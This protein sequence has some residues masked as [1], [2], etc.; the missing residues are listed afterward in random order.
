M[1]GTQ[2]D[3]NAE[4]CKYCG[5][6]FENFSSPGVSA[7]GWSRPKQEQAPSANLDLAQPSDAASTFPSTP[8]M[9]PTG[10]ALFVVSRSL[11]TSLLPAIFYLAF[12]IFT[13]AISS[14]DILSIALIAVFFLIAAVPVLFTPRKYEF[15]EGSLRIH[16]TVGR[17]SEIPYSNLMLYDVTMGRRQQIVL[18]VEGQRRQIL[19][20]GNPKNQELGQDLKQF[21]EQRVKKYN[22]QAGN[23][24]APQE[25]S[26]TSNE[27]DTMNPDSGI[28][29]TEHKA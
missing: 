9:I 1:C 24:Q 6:I 22:P 7:P 19:I 20:P 14:L 16:K 27:E 4:S 23:E 29:A 17:D 18:S 2:N 26:L 25:E 8:T 3:Q 28:D 21:L 5:Y 15:Y 10:S 11:L 13:N 12:I